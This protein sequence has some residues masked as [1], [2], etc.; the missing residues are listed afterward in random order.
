MAAG[1]DAREWYGRALACPKEFPIGSQ[2]IIRGS[3]WNLADGIWTCLDR[4]GRIVIDADGIVW[5][6]LLME[7][8]IWADVLPVQVVGPSISVEIFADDER[9]ERR[10]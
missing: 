3:R 8:P 5:L 7:K 9:V 2:F 4:G 6:D 10:R 1:H